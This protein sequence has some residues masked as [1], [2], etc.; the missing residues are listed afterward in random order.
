MQ[1]NVTEQSVI[2][3]Y[4]GRVDPFSHRVRIVVQEKEAACELILENPEEP[5]ED[6]LDLSPYQMLPVLVDR[7]LVLFESVTIMQYLDER[8]PHPPL[9][10]VNPAE[11]AHIRQMLMRI[12]RDW[13]SKVETMLHASP[14][15]AKKLGK[16]ISDSIV[17]LEPIFD[18]HPYFF[19]DEYTL[20]DSAMAPIL[21][22]LDCMNIKI[23][24]KA[25][26]I[27]RYQEKIFDSDSFQES[28]T[29]YEEELKTG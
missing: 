13:T 6:F 2:T 4:S 16:E 23:P 21:W 19:Y 26:A 10:P 14:K 1:F 25:E 22:H 20:L 15:E 12:D 27:Q 18:Q 5:S 3:I 9:M 17:M 8:Y 7:D 29:E 28:L 24:A 11:R